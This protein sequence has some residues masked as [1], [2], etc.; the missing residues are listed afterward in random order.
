MES[1]KRFAVVRLWPDQATAEHEN[2]QRIKKA[3]ENIGYQMLQIDRNGYYVDEPT[4]ELSS[5]DVD[6]VIHL[7]YETPK[8]YDAHSYVTL[9]NPLKFYHEWGYERYTGHLLSHDDFISCGSDS[10]DDQMRRLLKKYN[11]K[12]LS[13]TFIQINHTL[14]SPIHQP[15]LGNPKIFY[16]GINWERLGKG[17]GRHDN[18]LKTLDKMKILRIYGP[19]KIQGIKVWEGYDC[20]VKPIPFDGQSLVDEISKCGISLVFSSDAHVQSELMSNRLFE[21]IAGGAVIICDDNEFAYKN[22]GDSLL[23][24]DYSEEPEEISKQ[25]ITHYNWI[26]ENREEALNMA[27]KAQSIFLEKFSLDNQLKV[28]FEENAKRIE[29]K[30][31]SAF[32]KTLDAV[33]H[34]VI[35]LYSDKDFN[36]DR[37][38]KNLKVQVYTNI[39]LHLILDKGLVETNEIREFIYR[40]KQENIIY[41]IHEISLFKRNNRLPLG[42]ALIIIRDHIQSGY[43]ILMNQKEKW[44]H[45]HITTLVRVM[46]DTDNSL[47]SISDYVIQHYNAEGNEFRDYFISEKSNSLNFPILGKVL[48]SSELLNENNN[49]YINYLDNAILIACL[50]NLAGREN[51]VY[52]Q[53]MTCILEVSKWEVRDN[54]YIEPYLQ[55]EVLKESMKNNSIAID[56][57]DL[58]SF[59]QVFDKLEQMQE[60]EKRKISIFVVKNLPVPRKLLTI[61]KWFYRR[62]LKKDD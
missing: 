12:A 4:K 44:F 41:N 17:K 25:I 29:L 27:R 56:E 30:K 26:L 57:E 55:K 7:H 3:A 48:F 13:D 38:I 11:R 40:L 34:V 33:V 14:A 52:T 37:V 8:V 22:F 45:E 35:P 28:L 50:G 36:T 31:E 10:A 1:I 58:F 20:Y 6:L 9:W 15:Q 47:I 61:M 60:N 43:I 62:F 24:V 53:K 39:E 49:I 21:S 16:C 2:I 19:D 32:A 59:K 42:K 18:Y 23:Y 46:K 51:T 5:G 54:C